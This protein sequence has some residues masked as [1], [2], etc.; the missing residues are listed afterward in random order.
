GAMAADDVLFFNN[1]ADDG[2]GAIGNGG[3]AVISGCR[4]VANHV[5]SFVGG[6]DGGGAIPN[7]GVAASVSEFLRLIVVDTEFD[8]NFTTGPAVDGGAM[9]SNGELV[10]ARSLFT[11]N[12]VQGSISDGGAIK[13]NGGDTTVI[14]TTFSG[15]RVIGGGEGGAMATGIGPVTLVHVTMTDNDISDGDT[16]GGGALFSSDDPQYAPTAINSTFHGNRA[17]GVA[18]ADVAGALNAISTLIE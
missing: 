3:L 15:N 9:V 12:Y 7:G 11:D 4:F 6:F 8:A 18:G 2:G 17:A 1:A 16:L 14:N 13:S 10:I 5:D